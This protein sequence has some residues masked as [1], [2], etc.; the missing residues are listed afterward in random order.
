MPSSLIEALLF[1]TRYGLMSRGR[2]WCY[3]SLGMTIGPHC[4]LENIRVRRP[5]QIAIGASNALTEGCWLWPIDDH[6]RETRIRIGDRNY[7]NRDVMI[8]ACGSVE[9]GN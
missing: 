7:F 6:S 5:S 9:V 2:I 1:R 4:R 3:R 8:D